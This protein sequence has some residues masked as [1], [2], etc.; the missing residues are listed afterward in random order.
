MTIA[1]GKEESVS[2][3]AWTFDVAARK[4][5][6]KDTAILD[7]TAADFTND[8][9]TLNLASGS[10]GEWTLVN[11]AAKT[12]YGKFDVQINGASILTDKIDLDEMI[13]GTGTACDGWGFTL[14]DTVLKFKQLA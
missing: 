13:A 1:L 10:V 2:N 11:A 3:G 14:E 6:L 12:S 4:T 8:T 7:W 5:Y 9:I